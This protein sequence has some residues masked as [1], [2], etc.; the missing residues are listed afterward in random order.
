MMLQAGEGELGQGDIQG[1]GFTKD[2]LERWTTNERQG[3]LA[4]IT[5]MFRLVHDVIAWAQTGISGQR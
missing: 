2:G 1:S 3:R 4:A 5:I